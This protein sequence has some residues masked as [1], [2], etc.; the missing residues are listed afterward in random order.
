MLDWVM[1][2][3]GNIWEPL[4]S[5]TF[6]SGVLNNNILTIYGLEDERK[7]VLGVF[8]EKLYC[9]PWY[10]SIRNIS[11]YGGIKIMRS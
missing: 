1:D 9:H 3:R 6:P 8:Y 7:K 4:M 5:G 11:T 2:P 10:T